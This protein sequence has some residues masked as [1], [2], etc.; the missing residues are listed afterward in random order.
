MKRSSLLLFLLGTALLSW[1]PVECSTNVRIKDIARVEQVRNNQLIGYGLVV[2]LDGTG[3]KARTEFTT[4][5]LANMIE[6][7]GV[8]VDPSVIKVKNVAAV[9]VTATLPPFVRSG[10]RI[11]VTVSSIGDARSLQGGMLLMTPL[12]AANGLTY[13]V[14]Q[15]PLSL[16]GYLGGGGGERLVKNHPTVGRIPAGALVE[17]EVDFRFD[18]LSSLTL[19]L[20]DGDFTTAGNVAAAINRDLLFARAKAVDSRAIASG[21]FCLM[22]APMVERM[23]ATLLRL[24]ESP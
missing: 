19:V 12:K 24:E 13:G 11:D 23:N 15:G 10:S 7:I 16:G 8:T 6:K 14:A 4:Q 17:R 1:R 3:D 2:G 5:S 21:R 22:L 20:R 9:V 18:Q